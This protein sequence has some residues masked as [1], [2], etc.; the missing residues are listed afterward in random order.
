MDAAPVLERILRAMREARL[1]AILIGN[2]AAALQGAPVTTLDFDFM[3]RHSKANLPKLG[4]VAKKL[5]GNLTQPQFPMSELYRIE[6]PAAGIQ[7]DLMARIHG[8]RK[9]ESLRSR[10]VRSRIGKEPILVSSL[11]DVIKSKKA[12]GRK[13][14]RAVLPVLEETLREKKQSKA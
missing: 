3:Y 2:A 11:E 7:V 1:E 9:F 6:N 8:V 12:A 5:G 13:K 14:D 4:V 10:A